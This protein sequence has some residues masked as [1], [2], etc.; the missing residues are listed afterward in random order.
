MKREL[1]KAPSP[2][3]PYRTT[4][5]NVAYSHHQ[6]VVLTTNSPKSTGKKAELPHSLQLLHSNASIIEP[7]S[8]GKSETSCGDRRHTM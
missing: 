3:S 4:H 2:R 5:H 1:S 8:R 7:T 6:V